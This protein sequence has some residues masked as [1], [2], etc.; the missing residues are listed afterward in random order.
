MGDDHEKADVVVIGGGVTGVSLALHAAEHGARV[1]LMEANEIGW[2]ASGR[3]GGHVPPATKLEP[4]KVIQNYGPERGLRLLKAV[5]DAPAL[6]FGI[7]ERNKIEAEIVRSG[8]ITAAFTSASLKTLERREEFWAGQRVGVRTLDHAQTTA[9][10]G[11]DRYIGSSL[12]P[13]GGTINTLA[14]VRGMARAAIAKGVRIYERSQTTGYTRDQA[15]WKVSTNRGSIRT[16]RVAICTNAYSNGLSPELEQSIVPVRAYQFLTEPLPEDV[17][18]TILPGGQGVT[19]TRRLM[20]GFR[21]DRSG[22]LF[23]SGL[24]KMFAQP[25]KPDISYSVTRMKR[26]FPQLSNLRL[27]YWWTGW[28]AM[29]RENA[30]KLHELAPGIVAALGCNGRGLAIGTMLGREIADYF[31]GKAAEDLLLPISPITRIP[32]YEYRAQLVPALVNYYRIRDALDDRL[33]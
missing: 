16:D 24:G 33:R 29:N 31:S 4:S 28:M 7:A 19:D 22:G 30:W 27:A 17:Q 23:F 8:L 12:D 26:L 25:E 1:V 18:R 2:G 6:V 3:N 10:I 9:A 11:T 13:R 14:F 5:G 15:A 20:S 32:L 21:L